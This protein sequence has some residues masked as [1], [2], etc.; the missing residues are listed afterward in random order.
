MW[1]DRVSNPGRLSLALSQ[2]RH[3]KSYANNRFRLLKSLEGMR[4]YRNNC[5]EGHCSGSRVTDHT[6][7]RH[8]FLHNPCLQHLIVK[9]LK[10][11]HFSVLQG[12]I[13]A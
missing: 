4:L 6:R 1:P 12:S 3:I 8:F 9:L 5:H 13:N 11:Y 2:T 7:D 10:M